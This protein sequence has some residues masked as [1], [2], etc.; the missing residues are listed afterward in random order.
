MEGKAGVVD[1]SLVCH[2][3][4]CN[5]KRLQIIKRFQCRLKMNHYPKINGINNTNSLLSIRTYLSFLGQSA[6]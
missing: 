2:A 3:V 1:A 5:N 4:Y 6:G